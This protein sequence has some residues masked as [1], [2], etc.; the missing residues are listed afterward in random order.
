MA[1][2]DSVLPQKADSFDILLVLAGYIAMHTTF[3]RL[4]LASRALGSNFWLPVAILSSSIFALLT[5]LPVCARLGIPLDPIV[6]S[7]ALPF[8]VCTVG[9]DKPLR[10]ARAVFAHPDASRPPSSGAATPLIGGTRRSHVK[11]AES[12]VLDAFDTVGAAVL[13]DYALEIA[14]LI[15]GAYSRVGGLRDL[16]AF[17]AVLLCLDCLATFSFYPAV[18]AVMVEV[19]LPSWDGLF[20]ILTYSGSVHRSGASAPSARCRRPVKRARCATRR[21]DPMLKSQLPA[22]AAVY[23]RLCWARRVARWTAR[24]RASARTRRRASSSFS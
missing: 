8:I 11:A 22:C 7:E 14:V 23:P 1:P 12:V 15:A 18:L 13:R 17:A 16:C 9:F 21:P 4:F 3:F 5:S 19:S 20:A 10:A 6:L 2:T 24:W